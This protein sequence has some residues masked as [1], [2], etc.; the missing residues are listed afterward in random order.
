MNRLPQLEEALRNPPEEVTRL[1]WGKLMPVAGFHLQFAVGVMMTMEGNRNIELEVTT[2]R[3]RTVR[4]FHP[5]PNTLL[6]NLALDDA[7]MIRQ[8]IGAAVRKAS[9]ALYEDDPRIGWRLGVDGFLPICPL[10]DPP[11]RDHLARQEAQMIQAVV[12]LP[13]NCILCGERLSDPMRWGGG[14]VRWVHEGCHPLFQDEAQREKI[15]AQR[16][17]VRVRQ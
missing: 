3:G 16:L 8:A 14:L 5:L 1:A 6:S 4:G 9:M 17:E 10:F 7:T 2:P 12:D 13:Y 11:D 15:D